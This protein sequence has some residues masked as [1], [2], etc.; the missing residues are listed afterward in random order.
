MVKIMFVCHGN[1][2][3]SPM[4]ECI[5]EELIEKKGLEKEICISSSAISNEEIGNPIYPLAL[6]KLKNERIK[7]KNHKATKFTVQDYMNYD[8]IICMD[9]DNIKYLK[10]IIKEDKNGKVYRLLDFTG[11]RRD[12]KDPW[13]TR[14]FDTAYEDIK[15][16]CNALLEYIVDE[17]IS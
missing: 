13:Y 11:D 8:L 14:D 3:R 2:C 1:I 16:G 6:D 7:I 9:N 12:I 5:M 10:D 15:D 17:K 4:A